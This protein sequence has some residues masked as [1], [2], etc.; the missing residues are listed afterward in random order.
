MRNTEVY[1]SSSVYEELI[2]EY[3][4]IRG[5]SAPIQDVF[6]HIEQEMS[7]LFFEDDLVELPSGVLRWRKQV[8]SAREVMRRKGLITGVPRK[9]WELVSGKRLAGC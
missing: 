1:H 7:S 8:N 9:T 3:L 2:T 6:S 4:T 5:G